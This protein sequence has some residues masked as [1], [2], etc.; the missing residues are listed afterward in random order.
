MA[1]ALLSFIGFMAFFASSASS[2]DM[3][4]A[5]AETKASE[6]PAASYPSLF[7]HGLA[8]WYESGRRTASGE[9]FKPDYLTAAHRSLPF[10]TRVKVL[11]PPTGRSVVVRINDRGPFVPGRLLDLSRGAAREL[12]VKGVTPVSVHGLE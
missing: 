7:E 10:G 6:S 4:I 2:M 3:R 9:I 5:H 1:T 12:G 11:N 8:S